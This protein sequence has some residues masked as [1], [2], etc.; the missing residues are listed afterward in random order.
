M[1]HLHTISLQD[2]VDVIGVDS[3]QVGD[4]VIC[5]INSVT[6]P[7]LNLAIVIITMA[8]ALTLTLAIFSL[9]LTSNRFF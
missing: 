9:R 6:I 1:R 3:I 8:W 4:G 7:L 5:C 2:G